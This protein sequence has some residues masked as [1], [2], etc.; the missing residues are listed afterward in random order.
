M[1][2]ISIVD[3]EEIILQGIRKKIT[4]ILKDKKCEF[5]IFTFSDGISLLQFC[6]FHKI[7]LL[8]LDIDMPGINGMDVAQKIRNHNDTVEIVFITNQDEMVYEAI[9]YTPFRFI[10]KTKFDLEIQETIDCYFEKI[11]LSHNQILFSTEYG[12]RAEFILEIIYIEVRSHKLTVH[13]KNTEFE[14]NGN[15]NSIA[16]ELI[17]DGFIRI[18]QS[19]LVNFRYIDFIRQKWV[20]LDDGTQLPLSRS[21]AEDARKKLMQFS[22]GMFL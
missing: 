21:K 10:R 13:T 18:H 2:I 22:R 3:D 14:A 19:Y 17:R 4:K 15:L 5:E 12:K 11:N 1:T 20:I 8:F 16:P 6:Q 9:K 7:D